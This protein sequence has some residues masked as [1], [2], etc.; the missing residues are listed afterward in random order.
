MSSFPSFCTYVAQHCI[1]KSHISLS[2]PPAQILPGV[3]LRA[4]FKHPSRASLTLYPAS[5][6]SWTPVPQ[7]WA[8]TIIPLIS[9]HFLSLTSFRAYTHFPYLLC[10]IAIQSLSL[11]ASPSLPLCVCL[12]LSPSLCPSALLS[13]YPCANLKPNHSCKLTLRA[14]S[15]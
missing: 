15:S 7:P 5:V 10:V 14:L 3:A 2:Y 4:T 12:R 13:D 9:I 1:S 6:C 11:S 8:H